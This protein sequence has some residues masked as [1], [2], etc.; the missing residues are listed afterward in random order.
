MT[1]QPADF[2]I[3]HLR[4]TRHVEGGSFS[5]VYRS[6]LVFPADILPADV[7]GDRNASTHIYFLLEK[8]QFSAFHR[9]RFDELWHFYTGDPLTVCEIDEKGVL[10]QHLLGNDPQ[11]GQSHFCMIKGGSWFGSKVNEGGEYSLVG[12]TVSPGFDFADFELAKREELIAQLPAYKEII[13][14]LTR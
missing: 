1:R 13:I 9:I 2:W 7:K 6:P 12:C 14:A 10:H 4:L 8:E 5:E 11:A 3:Q